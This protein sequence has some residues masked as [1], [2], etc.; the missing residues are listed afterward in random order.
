MSEQSLDGASD[1][2][3]V[4]STPRRRRMGCAQWWPARTAIPCR[5][6]ATPISSV[7]KP[8]SVN[9]STPRLRRCRSGSADFGR[10]L[11][12]V[13]PES[14]EVIG[15]DDPHP[16]VDASRGCVAALRGPLV[17]A[18]E[19]VDNPGVDVNRVGV[20]AGAPLDRTRP[21]RRRGPAPYLKRSCA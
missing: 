17:Y 6:S 5:S 9:D 11:L 15:P 19:S 21:C 3:T 13:A 8:S 20:P 1:A 14:A 2:R 4:V 12:E 7:F 18:L 10:A 16:E